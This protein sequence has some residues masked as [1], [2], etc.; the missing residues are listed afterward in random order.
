M[1]LKRDDDSSNSSKNKKIDNVSSTEDDLKQYRCPC[2]TK[3]LVFLITPIASI[4]LFLIIFLPIYLT[5]KGEKYKISYI[6]KNDS[7]N[8]T[9]NIVKLDEFEEYIMNDSYATLTPKNGY[10]NIYIH[11]GNIY[12][13]SN[14]YFDFFKSEFTII[15]KNTKLIFLNGKKRLLKY[16]GKSNYY[17][18]ISSWYNI[19]DNGNLICEDCNDIYDEA[20]ESLNII[21]DKIEEIQNEE[22]INYDKIFL[23][24]Y[25]Q[26]G[27]MVNYA[28][29]N[30][31]HKL[32][33]Y[34]S[35][36]GYFFEHHFP[37][38]N[39]IVS[40]LTDKQKEIL[41]SKK[42]YNIL[43]TYSFNDDLVNYNTIMRLYY[44]YY[45]KYTNIRFYS[46]KNLGF[47][48][49]PILKNIKS[50]LNEKME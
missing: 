49:M 41:E 4:A 18:S 35:F 9:D 31:R 32:G 22:K 33:G 8:N 48:N 42:E 27:A 12:E 28:L 50:W 7:N 17:D 6:R 44:N 34:C 10:K 40:V 20:K 36:N 25:G 46:F 29:L 13:T 5:N 16:M 45:K 15:P 37:P 2:T 30:S 3:R 47:I 38:D 1:K 14:T 21:W 23:G 19:D 24:G 11:L 43:A 26:G 39:T